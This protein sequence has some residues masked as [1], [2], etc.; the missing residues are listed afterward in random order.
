MKEDP[1]K[2]MD[3]VKQFIQELNTNKIDYASPEHAS[4]EYASPDHKSI[5]TM[6]LMRHTNS[7]SPFRIMDP[8]LSTVF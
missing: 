5:T 2:S 8:M 6:T 1:N 7:S 3:S 4:H